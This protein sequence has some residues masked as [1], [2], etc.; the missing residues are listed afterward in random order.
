MLSVFK[1]VHQPAVEVWGIKIL[2]PVTSL[3]DIMV[4]G[5]CF[6]AAYMIYKEFYGAA[7]KGGHLHTLYALSIMYFSLMGVATLLGGIFG[8]A[9][10][11]FIWFSSKAFWMDN[12]HGFCGNAGEVCDI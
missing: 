7:K 6:Y 10:F 12:Q 11:I 2:E 4:S 1:E 8:H 5:V 9:F 3:T